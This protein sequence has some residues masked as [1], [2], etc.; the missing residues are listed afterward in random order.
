MDTS[1]KEYFSI[2]DGSSKILDENSPTF[3][4]DVE[5]FTSVEP[6]YKP[7]SDNYIKT[8]NGLF[9]YEHKKL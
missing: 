2:A 8:E 7:L 6:K 9:D 5:G 4:Q 3:L 1:F